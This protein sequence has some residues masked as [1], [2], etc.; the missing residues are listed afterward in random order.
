[1]LTALDRAIVA[2][3][4][5]ESATGDYARLLG[6][7]PSSRSQDVD[8]GTCAASFRLASTSLEL[9]AAG[10]EAAHSPARQWLE[11]S[12][13][14]LLGLSFETVDAEACAA[15]LRDRGVAVQ[16]PVARSSTDDETGAV[17]RWKTALISP[18]ASHGIPI[19]VTC[20]DPD[21]EVPSP[22]VARV[23]ACEAVY[24]LDHVVISTTDGDWARSFYADGLGLRLALDRSFEE[25][26]I[27]ILF[28]RIAGVTVE[29]VTALEVRPESHPQ[30]SADRFGG[31]A[32]QVEDLKAIH[33]RL[34]R[35]G[36]ELSEDRAGHKPGTR[37]CTLR[38][39]THGVPTLL[40]GVDL[41]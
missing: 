10:P 21:S 22:A 38:E 18:A 2:V 16:E 41:G 19:S 34:A 40:I 5:L 27:R 24:D 33:R 37:V 28:F 17:R 29:V 7:P 15:W 14:G 26:G 4:D 1:M 6:R 12:G 8:S 3:E 23:D 36:F 9:L 13:E 32:W 31:L 25:R 35:E 39:Q 11:A 30:G 20:D